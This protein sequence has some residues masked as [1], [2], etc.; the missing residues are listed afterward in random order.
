MET[1]VFAK[2]HCWRPTL[3]KFLLQLTGPAFHVLLVRD[4]L[5]LARSG[6]VALQIRTSPDF[7][8]TTT[9]PAHHGVGSVTF[10]ITPAFSIL[11]RDHHNPGSPW[12]R[13]GHLRNHSCLVH[14]V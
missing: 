9:I 5:L 13:V 11:S 8:G 4:E 12:S 14:S 7:F 6:L 2:T 1:R 3:R 10:E